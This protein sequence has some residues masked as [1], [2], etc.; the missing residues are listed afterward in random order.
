MNLMKW[1]NILLWGNGNQRMNVLK[2]V[3][4][5]V[6]IF[7]KGKSSPEGEQF[8]KLITSNKVDLVGFVPSI[9]YIRVNSKDPEDLDVLWEHRFSAPTVLYQLKDS[10]IMLLV[11]PNVAYNNSKL[12]EIDEN[13]DL[14][15]IRDLKGIIG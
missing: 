9:V 1:A 8:F 15:E 4:K 3:L 10:P 14:I 11:N 6:K 2:A 5:H 13:S 12:L 7:K